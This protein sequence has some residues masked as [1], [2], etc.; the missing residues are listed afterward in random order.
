V[1]LAHGE[2]GGRKTTPPRF[3]DTYL[4]ALRPPPDRRELIQFEAGTGLGVRVSK[5]NVS[6]I[7][8]LKLKDGT[9]WRE[10]LGAYG[11]LTVE[12]ARE[13]AQALAGDIAKGVDLHKARADVVAAARAREETKKFTLRALVDCWC[14]KHLVARRPGYARR[15][16]SGVER[17]FA[18]L[19]DR[20]AALIA[21]PEVREALDRVS[22][23]S[24]P[25]AARQA[26]AQALAA[27]RWAVSEDLLQANPLDSLKLPPLTPPRERI[28]NDDEARRVYAA[29]CR[30]PY[31][32][33]AYVRLLMLTGCR[34]AEIA[35]L[36]WEE[37][38]ADDDEGRK[39]LELPPERMKA[40]KPH[41]VPLSAAALD[42]LRDCQRVVGCAYVFSS[43]G[44]RAINNFDRLKKQLDEEVSDPPLKHWTF[45]DL[46]RTLVTTLAAKGFDPVVIDL[47]LGHQPSKLTPIARIYQK[48]EHAATRRKALETWAEHLTRS[49]S[50]VVAFV[51]QRKAPAHA[52]S[53]RPK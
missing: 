34:R 24:G 9:R 26:G 6:F 33:G 11:K 52:K 47:L 41:R 48:F 4:R 25:G 35:G 45:H 13:A 21:K 1:H 29:A 16:A 22:V 23:E 19:L 20:P 5:A 15:A 8:Q 42:T 7:V 14:S 40:G 27:Y 18:G 50:E 43:D 37:I 36:R 49:S 53:Q 46:R 3:S 30:L 39:A 2:N 32:G 51:P 38:V 31:P 44:W 28:L 10:T 12:A 17:A